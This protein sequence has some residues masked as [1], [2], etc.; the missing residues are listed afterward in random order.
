MRNAATGQVAMSVLCLM[1]VAMCVQSFIGARKA[2]KEREAA[3]G[4]VK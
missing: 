2:R 1:F 3:A 4:G